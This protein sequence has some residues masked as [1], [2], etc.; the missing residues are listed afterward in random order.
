MNNLLSFSSALLTLALAPFFAF[1]ESTVAPNS[2]PAQSREQVPP[3]KPLLFERSNYN[4]HDR[5]VSVWF[6]DSVSKAAFEKCVSVTPAIKFEVIQNYSSS[7]SIYA[8][9]EPG[10]TYTVR[11]APSLAGISSDTLGNEEVIAFTAPDCDAKVDFLSEGKLFPLPAPDFSLPIQTV[12]S[13][14][15]TLTVR[16]AYADS[17]IGFFRNPLDRDFS[18]EIFSGKINPDARQN[19]REHYSVDLEKIGIPRKPGIYSINLDAK[20]V[21]ERY[22]YYW[23]SKHTRTVIVTGLALQATANDNELAV[24]VKSISGNAAVPN[25]EIKIYSAKNRLIQTEKCDENGFAKITLPPLDDS[26]DFPYAIVAEKGDDKTF[27]PFSRLAAQRGKNGF[28]K[29][30]IQAF[31]FPERGICRPGEEIHLFANLV[32]G[33]EKNARGNVPAEF[34]ISDPGG[35]S[36]TRIPVVGDS[37]GFYKT[38]VKIPDFAAT[39]SYRVSLRIPG[40]EESSYGSARFAVGEYVPD[41]L[42]VSLSSEIVEDSAVSV[43]GNVA[44]YFGMPLDG[45]NVRLSRRIDYRVFTPKGDEFSEFDFGL[46]QTLLPQSFSDYETAIKSDANGNFS[47]HIGKPQNNGNPAPY[48]TLSIVTASVSGSAGGRSVSAISAVP[49]HFSQFYFGTREKSSSESE[50]AFEICTLS[51]T[52]SRVPA[53]GKKFKATLERLEWSYVVRENNGSVSSQWQQEH[54]PAGEFEFDGADS[55]IRFPISLGGKYLLSIHD[56]AGNLIHTRNFWHYYGETGSRSRNLAQL[57]FRLDRKKYLPGESAKVTFDSPFT[58]SA[59]LLTGSGKI[60]NMR[61]IKVRTGENSFDVPIPAGINSGSYFFSVTASGKSDKNSP[62]LICR[63]FGVGVLPVDMQARKIFVKTEIPEIIR[64]GEKAKMRISLSDVAGKPVAG[65]LQIWAVDRGVLSLNNFETPDAFSYFFGTYDCPY[66]F[67]DNY[68]DFYPLLSL[69]K[70]LFGGGKALG[71]NKFTDEKDPSKKSAVVVL[72]TLT[73]PASGEIEAEFVPPDFDGSMRIMAFALNENKIGSGEKN[74][75]VREPVSLQ[76][77]APR[78]VAPG[79]SFEIIAEIFNTDLPEQNFSWEMIFDGKTVASEDAVLLKKGGKLNFRKNIVANEICGAKTAEL[80]IRN[81]AGE[82]CSRE[83]VSISVRTPFPQRE[84]VVYS[85]IAPGEEVFFENA[86]PFGGVFFGSPALSILESLNWLRKYP[87]GCLEQVSA[88]AFPLLSVKSL[89]AKGL[90]PSVF[91]ESS[92]TMIR[93]SLAKISTM[94]CYSGGYSMWP[95]MN[96]EWTAGTLFAIHFE[97]EADSGGFP[98][99]ENRCAEI[100]SFLGKICNSKNHTDGKCSYAV[101]L[102]SLIG[103]PRA[104]SFA[105]QLLVKKDLEDFNKFLLG[106]A[107]VESGYASEGMK[108]ILPLIEKDFWTSTDG[109]WDSCLDSPVRR[110]GI[111]LS[112]LSKIAPDVPANQRVAI[113]LQS[114]ISPNGHW[115]STQKNA[116]AAYGLSAYFENRALGKER[117]ILRIDGKESELKSSIRVPAGQSV[118]LKNIGQS[119]IWSIVKTR[120]KPKTFEPVANGFEIRR[121][122]LDREGKPVTSCNSGDLLTVKIRVYARTYF[123]S[124]VICDLLPGGLEIE[125]ETLATRANPVGNASQPSSYGFSETA[126]E[127]LFDRFLAFGSFSKGKWSEVTYSVRATARGKFTVPPV[128][129]ESMYEEEKCAAWQPEVTTFEVK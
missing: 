88:T 42:N 8:N 59:V 125:D 46:D 40:Q 48:V 103:D 9:F 114:Q 39:G 34:H 5:S 22:Y 63:T 116:W 7:F 76:M 84:K 80:V 77:T 18:K 75:V 83:N 14:E 100:K 56:E 64:P 72:E 2:A 31:V 27:L 41:T 66:H 50:R 129:V 101:Y 124:A 6:S 94:R 23:I 67:G 38:S 61:E 126:R 121:E 115:G 25:A 110:A 13:G 90:I 82:I 109:D 45:G 111:V 86:D 47:A 62:E 20:D 74:I 58:G 85:Q 128:Q 21:N 53:A 1:A 44:Y 105:K 4:N 32:D 60:E 106:A 99:S 117:G 127:R 104:A 3:K 43:S 52:S 36:L 93:S 97:I 92:T 33:K 15:I 70:K 120:E 96:I 29:N 118:S 17:A 57:S 79:D 65:K 89:A 11:I 69:D 78:A 54:I 102:L 24:A 68:A 122:Y 10:E 108:T 16:Q 19:K 119:P 123:E 73:V 81:A 55:V 30:E 98:L 37:F 91:A 49:M 71:R 107:L 12:N 51:P 35:N 113:F 26:E 28:A 112:T 95:N 87:Y